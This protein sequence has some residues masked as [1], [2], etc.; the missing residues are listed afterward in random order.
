[1][2]LT[3]RILAGLSPRLR[4]NARHVDIRA[5]LLGS[6]PALA[7]ERGSELRISTHIGVYPRAC[8]GTKNASREQSLVRGL[9]PRLRGN[10]HDRTA[11]RGRGGSIPALAGERPWEGLY[12]TSFR[13]YPRACGGT[14][15]N[16]YVRSPASGLSPRLRGN[17]ENVSGGYV[18]LRSIPA[19]AGERNRAE[20][21]KSSSE[22]YPRACGGTSRRSN[23]LWW[24]QGLSPRLRGNGGDLP[25][26]SEF[27]GSI[28]ALAGERKIIE[29]AR[30]AGWVYPRACGGTSVKRRITLVVVGLSPRLRG[31]DLSRSFTRDGTGSIPA[32]AGERICGKLRIP[33]NRV[34]PRACGGTSS[35]MG[36][37]STRVGL[38]PR[39]RGNESHRGIMSV[40]GG[41]IPALAGERP[42]SKFA[43]L[44]QRVYPRAC[45]GTTRRDRDHKAA[46]GLSPRLRGNAF[47]RRRAS[48][49][50]WVYPRACGGTIWDDQIQVI[51]KGL[52]P[53]LRGNGVTLINAK[54]N[55]G[56]IPALAGERRPASGWSRKRWVYPRACGGTSAD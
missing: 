51:H 47:A 56:S 15:S 52:S 11:E 3:R 54:A 2:P 10:G 20:P 36:F 25:I 29:M 53:R 44:C 23:T 37:F 42:S 8:G 38:S 27:T 39:L 26:R 34:Y 16:S 33:G 4:G 1:M 18:T 6:I 55:L 13:V 9:S 49:I 32:L 28:P 48:R 7:G 40:C 19:L 21:P 24:T 17:V 5:G 46:R 31:N 30:E 35:R 22:V 45:G 41:S 43:P 12:T 14:H 50:G